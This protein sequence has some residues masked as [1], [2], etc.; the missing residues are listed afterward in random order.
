VFALQSLYSCAR[1]RLGVNT[2]HLIWLEVN[3]NTL[4]PN[5]ELKHRQW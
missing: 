3:V 2:D 4:G 1:H 5:E